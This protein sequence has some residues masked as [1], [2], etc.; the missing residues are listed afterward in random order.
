MTTQYNEWPI[1]KDVVSVSVIYKVSEAFNYGQQAGEFGAH[2]EVR[3][4]L[5]PPVV[6]EYFPRYQGGATTRWDIFPPHV[7]NGQPSDNLVFTS[8]VDAGLLVVELGC[9]HKYLITEP[10]FADVRRYL[11]TKCAHTYHIDHGD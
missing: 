9:D 10:H 11:C 8:I 5:L 6:Q 4:A 2:R 1:N 7:Y 3:K